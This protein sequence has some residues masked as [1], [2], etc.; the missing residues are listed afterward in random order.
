MVKKNQKT[1]SQPTKAAVQSTPT[2]KENMA[3]P[4]NL[5]KSIPIQILARFA[6][7]TKHTSAV[8]MDI[9]FEKG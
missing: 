3:R 7:S 5:T 1:T 8:F 9:L 2:C 4:K 6:I